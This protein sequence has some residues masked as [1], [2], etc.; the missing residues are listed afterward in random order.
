ML[1]I[2]VFSN[3][4]CI[5]AGKKVKEVFF[6]FLK[7]ILS[8]KKPIAQP[9]RSSVERDQHIFASQCNVAECRRNMKIWQ[10]SIDGRQKCGS[11]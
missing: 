1:A 2:K 8:Q 9:K 5:I 10:E 11:W 6:L 7:N 3:H 4:N